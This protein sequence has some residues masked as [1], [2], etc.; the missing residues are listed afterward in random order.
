VKAHVCTKRCVCPKCGAPLWYSDH[1]DQHACSVASCAWT[2]KVIEK[3]ALV[4]D[5]DSNRR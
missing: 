3:A 1:W 4:L 2:D 5:N